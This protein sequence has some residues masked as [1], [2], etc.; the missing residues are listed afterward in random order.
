M[1]AFAFGLDPII[2]PVAAVVLAGAV[3]ADSL[4]VIWRSRTERTKAIA[5][6]TAV[7]DRGAD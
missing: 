3:V 4:H 2:A 6:L 7:T 5:R 1:A